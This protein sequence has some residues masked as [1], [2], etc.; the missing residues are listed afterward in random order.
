MTRWTRRPTHLPASAGVALLTLLGA[1][2]AAGQARDPLP[3][4]ALAVMVDGRIVTWWRSDRAPEAWHAVN[5]DVAR[6]VRW[7]DT[8]DAVGWGE[9][10]L[11]GTGEARRTDVVLVRI[12]PHHVRLRLD[13]PPADASSTGWL[14]AAGWSIALAP[15]NARVAMNAG[16]FTA[17]GAW[18]WLVRDGDEIQPPRFAPLAP[19]VVVDSAGAV[20]IVPARAIDSIRAAGGVAQAFQSYPTL[21]EAGRVPQSLQ[22]AGLGVDVAHRDARLALGVLPNGQVLIALTRFAGL[23]GMFDRL[24][25]GLTTPE[26]AALMGALGC[27]DAELL[28]GGVSGQLLVRD[29]TGE[30]HEWAGMRR[31]PVGLVVVSR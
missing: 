10:S 2:A 27:E 16:Q 18:G 28:D 3:P 20:R 7:H 14:S 22:R 9:L 1:V 30:A 21:L 8:S 13:L 31:V 15:A 11:R 4:S 19:A 26:M 5:G 25:F 24:P 6:A 12:D 17:G 23:G 29:A